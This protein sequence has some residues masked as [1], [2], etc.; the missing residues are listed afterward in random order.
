MILKKLYRE[1]VQRLV[2]AG[3]AEPEV[4]AAL[5]LGHVLSYSR[6]QFF[7]AM[8]QEIS[9]QHLALFNTLLSRRLFREPLAY[10]TGEQEFWSLPFSVSRKVLIPRPETEELLEKIFAT[11][12]EVGLPFG[13]VLDLGVG[14]GAITVVLARE[15]PE[16][17]V[18]GVDL[19][20]A[21]LGVAGENIVRHQVRPRTFL[22]NGDWLAAIK[23]ERRFALVVSNPPYIAATTLDTLQPE[24]R[25]FEPHR[26]LNGGA[27]GLSGI[28]ALAAQVH[29][30]MLA[31]GLF[32]ME[33]GA[34]Q[35]EAVLKIFSSFPEYDR[36]QVHSDLAG[37]PR[38][39]QARR[40]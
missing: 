10:I 7:L 19:S 17:L 14:S 5:L 12:R 28:R 31:G 40:C 26:A 15:L 3:V 22:L 36:L 33:I 23:Q 2:D 35:Q 16:R 18:F 32:F 37:L 9:P 20:L 21:A 11:V 27:D 1:S 8:E 13:P 29:P 6:T 39:F 4:E 38:I 30:V 34:D 25:D 24:V